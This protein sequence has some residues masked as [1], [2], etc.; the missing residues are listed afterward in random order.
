MDVFATLERGDILFLDT[1]HISKTGSDVNH[2]L[3][4][5]LPR[6]SSGVVIH[7]HDIFADFD[8]PEDWIYDQNRS[9]NEL[10]VLRAFLMYN[11]SFEIIYANDAFAAARSELI[12]EKCPQIL[13][14]Q[15]AGLW[16]RKK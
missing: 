15:G 16:L 9:W 5:I 14:N 13:E 7:F 11:E 10:Y 8:Y 1:T 3:F 6:L 2:E 4:E 12:S